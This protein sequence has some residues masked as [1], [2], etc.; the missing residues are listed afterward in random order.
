[1]SENFEVDGVQVRLTRKPVKNLSLKVRP[2]LGVVDVTAPESVAFDVARAFVIARLPW[3]RNQIAALAAQ[4]RL[5]VR[6]FV[7]RESH[8][9]W[10]KRCILEVEEA[11]DGP[12]QIQL[13]HIRL[14]LR[15]K[16][17]STLVDR[18]RVMEKWQRHQLHDVVPQLIKKWEPRLNVTVSSYF[19]QRM[20]TKWGACNPQEKTIRLN[21]ELTQRPKDLLEYVIV[22]EMVHLIDPTHGRS[23]QDLMDQ[24]LPSWRTLR[25][26]LNALPLPDEMWREKKMSADIADENARAGG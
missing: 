5:P 25:E 9:V 20:K 23:F 2:P 24:Y 13:D 1:M 8:F 21:L 10:G 19:L 11:K 15:V 26:E 22:H 17:G 14:K 7:E 12:P 3:V 18:R 6:R 16:P 4:A